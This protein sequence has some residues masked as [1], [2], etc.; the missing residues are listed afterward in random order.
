MIPFA[1][2]DS[3]VARSIKLFP[4]KIRKIIKLLASRLRSDF[5]K[6]M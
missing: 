4:I 1:F 6:K 5:V 3:I 2:P